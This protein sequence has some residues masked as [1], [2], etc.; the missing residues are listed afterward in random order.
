MIRPATNVKQSQDFWKV[1]SS[2]SSPQPQHP[3]SDFS[4]SEATVQQPLTASVISSA[5]AQQLLPGLQTQA[6]LNANDMA[7]GISEAEQQQLQAPQRRR[8]Q[9]Q[10]RLSLQGWVPGAAAALHIPGGITIHTQRYMQALWAAAGAAAANRANGST[11]SLHIQQLKSLES[12]YEYSISASNSDSDSRCRYDAVV[13]AAGAAVGSLQEFSDQELP[14]SLC[15]GYTLD[16][17]PPED[18]QHMADS[19]DNSRGSLAVHDTSPVGAAASGPAEVAST[20]AAAAAYGASSPSILGSPYLASQG[21]QALVVGATK[22]YG[23]TAQQA[24]EELGRKVNPHLLHQQQQPEAVHG[25]Y[26][27]TGSVLLLQ[28]QQWQQ[29][30]QQQQPSQEAAEVSAAAAEL[31]TGAAAV[32]PAILNWRVGG[33]RTGVRAIPPRTQQGT[34]PILGLWHSKQQQQQQQHLEQPTQLARCATHLMAYCW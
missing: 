34:V 23:W 11:V 22:S 24:F 18:T 26:H 32:W 13:V 8:Q 31:L 28:Q 5:T 3:Q 19:G 10:Q 2:S 29:L 16:M 6:P 12:L 7:S 20:A 25:D 4:A 27:L 15:Q 33:I 30:Q 14:L 9:R 21:G 1:H 17:M